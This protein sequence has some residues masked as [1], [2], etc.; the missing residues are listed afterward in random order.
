MT[1]ILRCLCLLFA[2]VLVTPAWAAPTIFAAASLKPALDAMAE[3]GLLGMPAPVRVYA[4]SSQLARQIAQGAPAH[5]YISADEKWMDWLQQRALLASESRHDLLGNTLVLVA[6]EPDVKVDLKD[7]ESVLNA[8]DGGRLAMA[9]PDSVPAGRYARE[10]LQAMGLWQHL[11]SQLAPTRDVR[12]ALNLVLRSQCPL[13]VV[14]G[15]D[16]TSANGVH[17]AATFPAHSHIPIIY[18][19]AIIDGH[20]NAESESLLQAL[21]SPQAALI[22]ERFGFRRL[23]QNP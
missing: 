18:P 21:R 8:L 1:R 23:P 15:S 22:W 13:G 14:Y 12:A 17:V 9:L 5:I 19:V 16:V 7:I 6:A 3:S 10:A 11:Q 2:I 4:A 20:R